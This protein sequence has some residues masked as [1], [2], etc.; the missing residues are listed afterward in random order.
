MRA[1]SSGHCVWL[2]PSPTRLETQPLPRRRPRRYHKRAVA[3]GT[4]GRPAA[5]RESQ[6]YGGTQDR[7]LALCRGLTVSIQAFTRRF[8]LCL[9]VICSNQVCS[10][11][12]AADGPE[13]TTGPSFRGIFD[14]ARLRC[15]DVP[16]SR[17]TATGRPWHPHNGDKP[18][19]VCHHAAVAC[20][21]PRCN[22]GAIHMYCL[23]ASRGA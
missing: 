11:V 1:S 8:D 7:G 14:L 9:Y 22:L 10:V 15:S 17:V 18:C 5:R 2:R 20:T 3:S 4:N 23:V 21:T 19:Y 16:C 13:G 12:S 6:L